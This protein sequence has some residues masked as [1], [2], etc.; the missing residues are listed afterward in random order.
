M[1][2]WNSPMCSSLPY[3]TCIRAWWRSRPGWSSR[4]ASSR[5]RAMTNLHVEH[6]PQELRDRPQWVTWTCLDG[7]KVPFDATTGKAARSDDPATWAM[8]DDAC[9]AYRQ[10]HHAGIGY[11][12][13]ADD[14]YVGIDLDDCIEA[15]GRLADW[16]QAIVATLA[17]YTEVSP[18][19]TGVKLWV[20]GSIPGSVKTK[21]IEI[22]AERRYF[23]VTGQ[24]LP[25]TPATI[26]AVESE[27][28]DL[29]ASLRPAPQPQS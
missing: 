17:T 10:R 7:Q 9:R 1:P 22:Y 14:P 29:Y 23:T 12:F 11:V 26:R 13:A 20:I 28:A 6:I 18:S 21:Q 2:C 8:F 15:D 24:Q 16:A 19:G 5:R 25:G 27:L 4:H 3:G